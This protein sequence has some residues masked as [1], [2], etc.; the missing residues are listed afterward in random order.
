MTLSWGGVATISVA[1][2]EI[3]FLTDN[4]NTIGKS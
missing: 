2:I 3:F 4:S 1:E